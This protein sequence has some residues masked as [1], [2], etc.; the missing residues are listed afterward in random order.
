MKIIP[1]IQKIESNLPIAHKSSKINFLKQ[2]K[3]GSLVSIIYYDLE[4]EQI[5][6]QQFT[7]I[8]SKIQNRKFN[9]KITLTNTFD[10]VQIDQQFFIFSPVV[11]DIT[12]VKTV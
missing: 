1:L 2:A 3:I 11:L 4:K 10:Q 6:L 8:C 5:R 7:G 9:S 12:V